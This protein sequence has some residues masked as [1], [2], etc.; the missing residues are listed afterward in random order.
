MKTSWSNRSGL[1]K[2]TIILAICLSVSTGVCY[3]EYRSSGQQVVQSLTAFITLLVM[4]A[5]MI[6]LILVASMWC[7]LVRDAPPAAS[8]GDD[9]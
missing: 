3:L 2:A 5:S 9:K 4:I 6:G 8:T 1:A 7:F